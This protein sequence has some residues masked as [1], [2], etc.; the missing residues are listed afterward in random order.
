MKTALILFALLSSQA[1]LASGEEPAA[2]LLPTASPVKQLGESKFRLTAEG[3]TERPF[4]FSSDGNLLAGTNYNELRIWTFPEGKLLQDLSQHIRTDCITFSKDGEKLFA[5]SHDDKSVYTFDV[6][7]GDLIE[8]VAIEDATK[9]K[10]L[11]DYKFSTDSEWI[12]AIEKH[13]HAN[14]W[15][16]STGKLLHRFKKGGRIAALDAQRHELISS[17]GFLDLYNVTTG[18][19]IHRRKIYQQL[20]GLVQNPSGSLFAAY[21]IPDSALVFVDPR[22]DGFVGGRI[23]AEERGWPLESAA[24]SDDGRRLVYWFGGNRPQDKKMTVFDVATGRVVTSFD[25]PDVNIFYQPIISPDGRYV[26]PTAQRSVF[27]AID[28]TTGKPYRMTPDH[29][30]EVHSLS[31]TPDG[32][33]LIVGSQ[34]KY[35]VWDVKSG[36]PKRVLERWFGHDPCVSAVDNSRVLISKMK[37][38]GIQLLD[39]A[40]GTVM[41]EYNQEMWSFV[42][43]FE[44]S[45]DKS[46]FTTFYNHHSK[47]SVI[48]C[49]LENGKVIDE[50]QIPVDE[51]AGKGGGENFY[52]RYSYRGLVLNGT[53][54]VRFDKI[55]S[56]KR[57][58]TGEIDW[59]QIDLVLEDWTTQTEASRFT[60]P[61]VGRFQLTDADDGKTLAVAVS[62]EQYPNPSR[63][64]GWGSTYVIVWNVEGGKEILRIKRARQDYFTA[65]TVVAISRDARLAA[66]ASHRDRIELWDI[67]TGKLLQELAGK[68]DVMVLKFNDNAS[69][70]ASGHKDGRVLL[71]DTTKALE[72]S[73]EK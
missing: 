45:Q 40:S 38:P 21:S 44:L 65:F 27:H 22:K 30:L 32:E 14:I 10:Q 50:W 70:L 23:P 1:F 41:R 18:E 5:F 60:I 43:K 9:E 61:A 13:S 19:L 15:E 11:R 63:G 51:R 26:V 67:A 31:F 25:P 34:D 62:D 71:W 37:E 55:R 57:L 53:R 47:K 4:C 20:N 58:S 68:N 6:Q 8:K 3:G 33:T 49:D 2:P 72:V 66:T 7:T 42:T 29:V 28:S 59:G 39:I 52:G 46:N 16:V 54:L 56:A 24:L 48:K 69:L 64:I 73:T 12:V 35:Q 36:E 17:D